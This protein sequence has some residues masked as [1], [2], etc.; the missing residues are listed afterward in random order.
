MISARCRT[1]TMMKLA[2]KPTES[3]KRP[4]KQEPGQRLAPAGLADQSGRIGAEA[5]EHRVAERDDAG[6]AEDQVDRDGEE[7]GDRDLAGQRQIGRKQDR[8]ARSAATQK[9]IS[10]ARPAALPLQPA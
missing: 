4:G 8:T 6:I 9:A 10:K 1:R 3:G 2:T 5:E 7:R